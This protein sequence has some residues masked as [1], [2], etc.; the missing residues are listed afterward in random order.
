MLVRHVLR[1]ALPS[2]V[3]VIGLIFANVLTG[4][5]L[6]E[7]IFAWPG[8]GQ[9]AY[10]SAVTLDLP[11]DHGRQHLRRVVYVVVNFVVDVLY[12]VIDPRIRV[13]EHDRRA[14]RAPAGRSRSE[15]L[16]PLARSRSR[17]S[18]PRSRCCGCSS[19]RSLRSW[20][21]D[22]LEQ[23][24]VPLSS[25]SADH[26]F[27]TDELGRDVFSRVV[28]GARISLPLGLLLVV[29]ASTIGGLLGALAGYFRGWVDGA[30]MRTADLVFAF[31]A[32]IL[33]MVV[34]AALGRGLT[35]AVL[36]LVIVAWPSYARVVRSLVLS[37]AESEYVWATRCSGRPSRRALARDVLP[38]VVGPV[39]VLATLDVGRR[40][41]P[42]LRALVPRPRRPAPAAGGARWW[43][44]ARSF[45]QF[46]WMGTFPGLAIFTAVLAFNFIG[47]SLR[48]IFDPHGASRGSACEP[49]LEVEG[50]RV[51]LPTPAGHVTVVDG[52]D[53]RVE[54]GEVFGIA[55]ESGSGKTM[56]V[57]AARA[58]L[59]PG[60]GRG[61]RPLRRAGPAPPAPGAAPDLRPRAR[62]RLPGPDDLAP[63]DAVRRDAAH[64]A[65]AQ[66]SR[67]RAARRQRVRSSYCGRSGSRIPR[68]RCAP[69]R[70]SSP[71]DAPADRDRRRARVPADAA[72]RGR[73]DHRARR[74][75]A[76][77]HHPTAR[78][79]PTRVRPRD[80]PHLASRRPLAI[81]DR[82]AVFYAGRIV[83]AGARADV[84]SAAAPV[85]A[86]AARRAAPS[87]AAATPLVAIG[88][89]RRRP[90]AFRPAAPSIRAAGT[91][92]IVR[93][94]VPPLA[95]VNG[96]TLACPVDPFRP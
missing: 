94:L 11:V 57:L 39:L 7:T 51:R 26:L 84:L 90:G 56:S 93:E 81:A 53:Y 45:F 72:R 38:N 46:W 58:L 82:V 4:T 69:S 3:T 71:G 8:I 60:A 86:R 1:A 73:A 50:L 12:G 92:S 36:A 28:Y 40:D 44:P 64:R 5:V 17:S 9:Y 95:P 62:D 91:R 66:P 59:P 63:S 70:T 65:R 68:A 10:R 43:R 13:H 49:L 67:S 76:G 42:P 31:P 48:D 47:D 37:V 14:R 24:F 30:V 55:G 25:P 34:T 74:H 15:W 21:Y 54:P 96:R 16:R 78:P 88:G 6:V 18:A 79:A 2:V 32:I 23:S 27:G 41:S 20:R 35:N 83:E 80:R 77:R 89:R 29:L 61:P 85:H 22:P 52:I 87:G 19:R 75:R 33:A